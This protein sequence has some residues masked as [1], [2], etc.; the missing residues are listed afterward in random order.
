MSH[1]LLQSLY[2]GP[3][4]GLQRLQDVICVIVYRFPKAKFG[5]LNFAKTCAGSTAQSQALRESSWLKT[6]TS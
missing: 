1:H 4:L 5:L 3:T 2:H 6:L